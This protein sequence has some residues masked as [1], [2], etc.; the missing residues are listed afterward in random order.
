MFHVGIL[1][2]THLSSCSESFRRQVETVFAQCTIILHAGDLADISVLEAFHGKEVHAVHG[3]MCNR[4]SQQLL[5]NSKLIT[6]GGYQIGLYHGAWGPRHTIEERVWAMFPQ[7]DCIVY[8]HTHHAVCHRVGGV[9]FIN[10]G[11][12]QSTGPFGAP[13]TCAILQI[14]EQAADRQNGL[15][16]VIYEV[17][18][19]S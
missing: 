1:S 12:F 7:A 6:I 19:I 3:N 18:R 17:L 16:A 5:P 10:P 11:T 14:D 4:E 15:Q 8:G 9:L 2:D 13:G